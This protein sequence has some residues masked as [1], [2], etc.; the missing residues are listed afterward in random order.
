M[1]GSILKRFI[2]SGAVA[3]ALALGAATTMLAAG[4][5]L[6]GGATIVSP[7]NASPHA[8][9]LVSNTGNTATTDDFSGI[10]FDVPAGTTFADLGTLSSDFMPEADDTC[11]G[12]SPRFQIAIDTDNDGDRDGNIFAYFGTD[13]GSPAC[14]PGVWQNTTD[15]L[16][17]GK[18][19]DTS[20]LGGTF[21]DPYA[22]ALANYGSLSVVGISLVVDAGW[23]AADKEQTFHIDNTNIDGTVYTYDDVQDKEECKQGG[24]QNLTREDGSPFKNQGDCVSYTNTG[25]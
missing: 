1:E 11:V 14:V 3:L 10:R 19:L 22:T 21:Y 24:W 23:A 4:Y 16:E 17:A 5:T 7:G 20:Q 18:L 9:Q 15:L 25:R 2:T 12:G 8:V 6:F 13:S